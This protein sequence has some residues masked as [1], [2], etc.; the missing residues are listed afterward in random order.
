MHLKI[1]N[2]AIIFQLGEEKKTRLVVVS[3]CP[4]S[5]S[6]LAVRYKLPAQQAAKKLATFFKQLGTV[7]LQL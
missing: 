3:V 1:I 2:V 5:I 7:S 6:S 4:Q